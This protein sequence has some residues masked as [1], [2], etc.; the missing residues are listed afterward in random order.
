MMENVTKSIIYGNVY[1]NRYGRFLPVCSSIIDRGIYSFSKHQYIRYWTIFDKPLTLKNTIESHMH[2]EYNRRLLSSLLKRRMS[3][4]NILMG[5]IVM[6]LLRDQGK[7]CCIYQ[8]NS[9]LIELF[10][11]EK[12]VC[13]DT[14]SAIQSFIPILNYKL[15][16]NCLKLQITTQ[17]TL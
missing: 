5:V 15:Q 8:R 12:C 9:V 1:Q 3:N 14:Y 2:I 16:S 17:R 10:R 4:I 6:K 11:C 13:V 7:N